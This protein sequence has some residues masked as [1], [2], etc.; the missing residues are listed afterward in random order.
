MFLPHKQRRFLGD[1]L[2][3]WH[4]KINLFSVNK[5]HTQF[6]ILTHVSIVNFTPWKNAQLNLLNKPKKMTV[7]GLL[8]II[9]PNDKKKT[10]I[11]KT[12]W[13]TPNLTKVHFAKSV[14][15]FKCQEFDESINILK[16]R[17]T[18][19]QSVKDNIFDLLV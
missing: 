7:W 11:K 5:M 8:R 6:D 1:L 2:L 17:V 16:K 14:Y 12:A 18:S 15:E 19:K 10:E 4:Q 13:Q 3:C 9:S